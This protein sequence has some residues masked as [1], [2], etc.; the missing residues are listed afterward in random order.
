[1]SL[2]PIDES[3]FPVLKPYLS[4]NSI[5]RHRRRHVT[6]TYAQ[7]IDSK[8]AAGKGLRTHI[9]HEETKTMTHYI[10][11]FHDSLVIGIGTLLADNPSLNCRYGEGNRITPIIID[12]TFKSMEIFSKESKVEKY[13][14]VENYFNG[15]GN[16][17]VVVISDDIEVSD[18]RFNCDIVR[19]RRNNGDGKL[20]WVSILNQC[21]DQFGLHKFMIE[22]GAYIINDLLLCP[23]IVDSLIIT[24]G[25]VFLG[26]NGVSVSPKT[27]LSLK[28]VTWWKGISDSV[29]CSKLK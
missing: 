3:L 22:G 12:P 29:M 2:H 19:I 5:H 20:S 16:K 23:D 28:N 26:E 9:S 18:D 17:P 25:P 10:R 6:L 24:I 21:E 8:I 7:S 14:L 11:S 4:S 1:M 27:P 15:S 13:K